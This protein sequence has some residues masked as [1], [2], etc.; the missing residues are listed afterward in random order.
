MEFESS[1][2]GIQIVSSFYGEAE[3][4]VKLIININKTNDRSE[5][6]FTLTRFVP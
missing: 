3:L 2:T 6:F 1:H 5:S 4:Q